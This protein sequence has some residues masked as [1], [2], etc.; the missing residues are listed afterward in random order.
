MKKMTG[1]MLLLTGAAILVYCGLMQRVLDRMHLRDRTALLLIGAMLAGTFLP[2]LTIG[3]VAVNIGGGLIPLGVCAYLLAK[4]D[5]GYERWRAL[6][7]S[8]V[9]G[10]AVYGL[11]LLLPS[12]PEQ[13]LVDPTV[14]VCLTGGVVGWVL[15]RSRR[16]AFVCGVAGVLLAD[17]ATAA[18]NWS[19][20]ISQQLM[21]GGGGLAD[22]AVMSGMLSVLLC[23][24]IGEMVERAVRRR[25]AGGGEG[26]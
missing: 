9:T 12:E 4:A 14:L 19:R 22:A 5:E 11:T 23:E 18:V 17:T 3:R 16:G 25:M 21:L 24:T 10:A 13:L 8:I 6:L 1:G 2:P 7:G 20:G 15:G 26:R